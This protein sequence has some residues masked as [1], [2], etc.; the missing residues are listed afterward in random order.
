M[1]GEHTK[2]NITMTQDYNKVKANIKPVVEADAETG[3]IIEKPKM[4][5]VVKQ[6]PKK[7]KKGLMERLVVGLLGPDGVKA[8]GHR[9]SQEIVVPAV[10][11]I[12]VDSIT[13]GIHMA[14]YGRNEQPGTPPPVQRNYNRYGNT[15]YSQGPTRTNYQG[16]Y[17][18]PQ[19]LSPQSRGRMAARGNNVIEYVLGSRQEA[20]DILDAL[21]DNIEE[22]GM[23]TVADYYDL[24]GETTEYTDNQWGW[25]DLSHTQIQAVRNGYVLLL[26]PVNVVG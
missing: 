2:E 9:L 11:N 14:I 23:A 21:R 17:A 19:Q 25:V 8:I 3:E 26:P 24:L 1:Y 4:K 16:A 18:P 15:G 10:K 22:Y 20:V 12:V 7:Y 13:S 5:A 6:K